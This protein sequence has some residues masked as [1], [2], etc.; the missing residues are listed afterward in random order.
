MRDLECERMLGLTSHSKSSLASYPL[1]GK[2]KVLCAYSLFE[3]IMKDEVVVVVGRRG[4][5]GVRR[6]FCCWK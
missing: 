5:V 1:Q 2:T 3:T 6:K 4:T